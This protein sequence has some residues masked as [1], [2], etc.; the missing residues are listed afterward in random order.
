MILSCGSSLTNSCQPPQQRDRNSNQTQTSHK[1]KF[2]M[3]S[4]KHATSKAGI[5][6]PL[7]L[8]TPV[9]GGRGE[10]ECGVGSSVCSSSKTLRTCVI[11]CPPISFHWPTK[12]GLL[13]TLAPQSPQRWTG[14]VDPG[15]MPAVRHTYMSP[16]PSAFHTDKN[17]SS[18]SCMC[19]V[20]TLGASPAGGE[21]SIHD[22]FASPSFLRL[23]AW[24][25]SDI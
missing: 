16:P 25:A 1:T 23:S 20:G 22:L 8:I 10:G 9:R 15:K 19:H 11:T 14:Q 18:S 2:K 6:V 13:S 21:A 12:P 7:E 4:E 3:C 24:E 5:E 17:H